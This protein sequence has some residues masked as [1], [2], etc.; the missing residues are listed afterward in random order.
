MTE[1]SVAEARRRA[2]SGAVLVGAR[3]IAIRAVGL[4]GNVVLARLLVPADFGLI[5][6]AASAAFFA[7]SFADFGLGAGL[8]R[9]PEVPTRAELAAVAGFEVAAAAVLVVVVALLG[10]P[11]GRAGAVATVMVAS[12]LLTGFRAPGALLLER[13]L[14]YRPLVIVEFVETVAFNAF[15]IVAVALGA[16]VWGLAIASIFRAVVGAALMTA[17]SP[18]GF[19]VPRLTVRL[20]RPLLSFGAQFQA[21]DTVLV[22]RGLL[23]S[24]GVA[25]VGGLRVLGLWAIAD[26]FLS[27]LS[28]V[29]ESLWRVSFP[30]MSRL[31]AQEHD[32]RQIV[33]RNLALVTFA[34]GLIASALAGSARAL[35]P[36]LLGARYADA[37]SAIPP[38]CLGLL[39]T[40]PAGVVLGGYLFARGHAR[41]VLIAALLQSAVWY[42]FA[43]ALL[44]S[45]GVAAIGLGSLAGSVAG[46]T[47]LLCSVGELGGYRVLSASWRTIAASL[48]AG[49]AGFAVAG[50]GGVAGLVAGGVVSVVAF[51]AMLGFADLPLLVRARGLAT[52]AIRDAATPSAQHSSL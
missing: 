19:V 29:I 21:V 24:T 40:V 41:N 18:V 11:F 34:I 20:L 39:V 5:S 13:T 32:V 38:A 31:L 9:R 25:A 36:T 27:V 43:F 28:L 7:S 46:T 44:P 16:G 37:A 52:L 49:T 15:A 26:R 42:A 30:L 12:V 50:L 33:R 22:T 51:L 47:A 4:A 14:S 8:I 48:A 23:L 1:I 10:L 6:F 45:L 35:V 17:V 2:A 3:G